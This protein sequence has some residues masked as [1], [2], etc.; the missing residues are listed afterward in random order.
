MKSKTAILAIFLTLTNVS[1]QADLGATETEIVAEASQ[2]VDQGENNS[3]PDEATTSN[4]DQSIPESKYVS[5]PNETNTPK[6]DKS[7]L[8][9]FLLAL[10]A[11]AIATAAIIIVSNHKGKKTPHN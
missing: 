8:Y 6:K 7:R 2:S 3:G 4:N 1:L 5:A 9:N 11:V 10:A